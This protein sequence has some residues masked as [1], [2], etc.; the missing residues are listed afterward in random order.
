MAQHLRFYEPTE[1]IFGDCCSEQVG[2]RLK[3]RGVAKP[4]IVTDRGVEAAGI[5]DKIRG[6][7]SQA[8]M[9]TLVCNDIK[10]NPT[11]DNVNPR[12]VSEQDAADIF[13]AALVGP[14]L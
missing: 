6:H 8:E 12:P 9:E 14:E 3:E 10:E 7:L 4:L 5:T 2:E 1:L 11:E 13:K